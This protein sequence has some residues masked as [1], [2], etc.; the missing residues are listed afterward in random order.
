MT[1]TDT[2]TQ[3]SVVEV[4]PVNIPAIVGASTAYVGFTG[5]TGTFTAIDNILT[6]SYSSN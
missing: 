6:W 2:L 3:A 4:F 5:S 1:L